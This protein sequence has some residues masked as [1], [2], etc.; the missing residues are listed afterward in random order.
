MAKTLH[1][2]FGLNN[3]KKLNVSLAQP[4]DDLTSANVAP[5]MAACIEKDVFRVGTAKVVSAL[6]AYIREVNQTD[7]YDPAG[8]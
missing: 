2:V 1:M 5:V 7:I 4:K 8:A 3:E 6:D